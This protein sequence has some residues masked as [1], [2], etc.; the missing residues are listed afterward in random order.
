MDWYMAKLGIDMYVYRTMYASVLIFQ[1]GQYSDRVSGVSSIYRVHRRR[2]TARPA[3]V[4]LH[5]PALE[6][7]AVTQKNIYM[8]S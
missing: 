3:A 8:Y 4:A 5:I 7:V 2:E 1:P 6:T